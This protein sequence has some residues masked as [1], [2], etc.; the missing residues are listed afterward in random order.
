MPSYRFAVSR[1]RRPALA[2]ALGW[3]L[4]GGLCTGILLL[5]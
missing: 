3:V 1:T 2:S 4:L 5:L